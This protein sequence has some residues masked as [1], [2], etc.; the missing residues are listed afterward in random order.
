MTYKNYMTITHIHNQKTRLQLKVGAMTTIFN[1]LP[2]M[3][4]N[5]HTQFKGIMTTGPYHDYVFSQFL[6]KISVLTNK[7]I[8]MM[9]A[10]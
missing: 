6:S 1:F 3:S 7:F 5:R 10:L 4:K 2:N 8:F 9:N